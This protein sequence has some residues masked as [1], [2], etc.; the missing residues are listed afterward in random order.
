LLGRWFSRLPKPYWALGYFLPLSLIL[1]YGVASQRPALALLPPISW[2]M[3]GR[4]K[5]AAIGFIT[6]MVLTTPLSRLP[7]KRDRIMVSILMALI[8][9]EMSVWPFLAPAFNR[10]YLAQ[11]QTKIDA[12]GVCRQSNDYNCGP[13]AA[14]T[15]LRRLDLAADEGEIAILAHTSSATGT[16]P[17]I[18]SR[19]LQARY[20][21]DGLVANYRRFQDVAE[22]RGAGF[23]LALVKFSFMLDHYVTVLEVNGTEVIVG[24]PLLGLTKLSHDAFRAQW[25]FTGVTLKRPGSHLNN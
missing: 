9:S 19:A 3:A 14:V 25:R 21:R 4:N 15:A 8:V 11:L 6:T 12:D 13:A 2:M 1:L 20:A 5:F 18:L 16:P 10:N 24:D 7:R 22:L 17:D 23:T